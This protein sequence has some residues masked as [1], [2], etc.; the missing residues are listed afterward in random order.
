MT[1]GPSP[2]TPTPHRAL[3]PRARVL[4]P[5]EE[6][7]SLVHRSFR[8]NTFEGPP[9]KYKS[10]HKEHTRFINCVRYN[11]TGTHYVT[12]SSDTKVGCRAEH[13]RRPSSADPLIVCG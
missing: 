7:V 4:T 9:F 11:S 2:P 8:I 10:S 6:P 13:S 12:V 3:R 1:W 5:C